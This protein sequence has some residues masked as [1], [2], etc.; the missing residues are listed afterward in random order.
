ML[1]EW[2]R[3]EKLQDDE[4]EKRLEKARA[5]LASKQ[6]EIKEKDDIFFSFLF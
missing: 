5:D 1:K 4:I 3:G 6:V 2:N